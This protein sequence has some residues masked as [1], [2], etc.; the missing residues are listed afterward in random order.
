MMVDTPPGSGV[1]HTLQLNI[2][3]DAL[4]FAPSGHEVRSPPFE[5]FGDQWQIVVMLMGHDAATRNI[6]VYAER[7]AAT[8]APEASISHNGSAAGRELQP[9][10]YLFTGS[11][12][13][14][15]YR[16]QHTT[17]RLRRQS[18]RHHRTFARPDQMRRLFCSPLTV[19]LP[20]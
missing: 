12:S 13:H 11:T 20:L 16:G 14:E 19:I 3:A 6:S 17:T 10:A 4:D 5:A 8:P 18:R 7:L 2:T 15:W 1:T 9:G